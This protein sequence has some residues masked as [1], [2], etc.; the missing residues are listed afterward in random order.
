MITLLT[1]L[2]LLAE[3]AHWETPPD[4]K[5]SD[6]PALARDLRINGTVT[7]ECVNN[8]DGALSR[9][10]AMSAKPPAFSGPGR[11]FR[12]EAEGQ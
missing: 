5:R 8:E 1:T 12:C 3:P 6:Y 9:C 11:S 7:L 10:A 4:V 2:A